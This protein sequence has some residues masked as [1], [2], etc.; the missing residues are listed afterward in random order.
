MKQ[1]TDSNY[2]TIAA[3]DKEFKTYILKTP[4]TYQKHHSAMLRWIDAALLDLPGKSVLEI[5][6]ATPR[7]ANYMRSKGFTVQTSDASESFVHYLQENNEDA[8]LLNVLSDPLPPA[9]DLIF[10][11]AVV[12]HFT[13]NETIGFLSKTYTS[14]PKGGR[15]AFSIKAGEGEKWINEKFERKRFIHYWEVDNIRNILDDQGFTTIFFESDAAGDFPN[16]HWINIVAQ[17]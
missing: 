5:G 9:F 15:V 10:A 1:I 13:P 17:K 6:S 16:H 3:Y 14:L 4:Q 8:L 7:D 12:P 11:N 2:T